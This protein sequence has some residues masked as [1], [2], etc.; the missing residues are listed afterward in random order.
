MKNSKRVIKIR[1]AYLKLKKECK[2]NNLSVSIHNISLSEFNMKEWSDE[3]FLT[4]EEKR[5]VYRMKLKS[6]KADCFGL[7]I[8]YDK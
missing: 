3:S 7:T 1:N 2:Q 4:V 8:F 6:E 5:I